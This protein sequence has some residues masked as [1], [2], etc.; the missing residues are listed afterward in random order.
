MI[1]PRATVVS[2]LETRDFW[3]AHN[4][5]STTPSESIDYPDINPDDGA[6]ASSVLYTGGYEGSEVIFYRI[7]GGGHVA[8]TIDHPRSR[9]VLLLLGLGHQCQDIEGSREAWAFL[10]RHTLD[11]VGTG[12]AP[13]E[14]GL[15][16]LTNSGGGIDLRWSGDCGSAARY[17]V[18]RG[19]LDVGY[20]SL[21]PEPGACALADRS[22]SVPLG[23]SEAE[24]FLVVSNDVVFEGS[25]GNKTTGQPRPPSGAPCF[26]RDAVDSCASH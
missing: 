5:V 24:F 26:T 6:T 18:Y 2:A 21:A 20:A 14:A 4:G 16:R 22:L 1:F 12:S 25:Y 11:G 23:T 17:G 7:H 15:L 13:G 3:I 19:D 10:E 8:P 9:L